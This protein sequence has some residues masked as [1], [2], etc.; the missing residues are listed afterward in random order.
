MSFKPGIWGLPFAWLYGSVMQIRNW[1]YDKGYIKSHGFEPFV[2]TVGNLSVG[3]T[4]KSPHV[5]YLAAS[6][7]DR[8]N[9]GLLSRG[10]GRTTKGYR[11][12]TDVETA[13]TVGD[14][15]WQ[16]HLKFEQTN[17]L[18]AV[19]E[20]RADG[21]PLMMLDKPEL[22]VI[23]LDDAYQHRRVKPALSLLL[24]TFSHPFW[25]DEVVPAG[26]LREPKTGANR[27][28]ALIITKGPE[29]ITTA[30]I[31]RFKYDARPYVKTN[32]PLFFSTLK[33]GNIKNLVTAQPVSVTPELKMAGFCGIA[34]PS[35]FQE[36]LEGIIKHPLVKMVKLGDHQPFTQ[37]MLDEWEQ[38]SVA[39]QID[40]WV[41]TSKDRARLLEPGLST[42]PFIKRCSFLP[43][44][45]S[46]VASSNNQHF[47][48]WLNERI[49]S[50]KTVGQ[51]D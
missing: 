36:A 21:I 2:I 25:Q 50:Y 33:Y 10:Y 43:I 11:K 20:R 41:C 48:D 35:Q 24:T 15:P 13:E 32:T 38:L 39:E 22:D 6:L 45:V 27:A 17:V 8:Y 18:I 3:G 28:D 5:E 12:V 46:F 4:G 29:Q 47:D 14:E 16:Y 31:E 26:W 51:M 34:V 7:L 44:N 9:I 23:I 42:H 40:L 1:L 37:T 49:T 19:H 30:E